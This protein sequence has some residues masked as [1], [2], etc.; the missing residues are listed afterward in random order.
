MDLKSLIYIDAYFPQKVMEQPSWSRSYP[1]G[2]N[3][4]FLETLLSSELTFLLRYD[5]RRSSNGDGGVAAIFLLDLGFAVHTPTVLPWGR[6]LERNHASRF[7]G[8]SDF[9]S[10]LEILKASQECREQASPPSGEPH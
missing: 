4:K 3:P 7:L 6:T 10:A 1:Q 8:F 5:S 2:R 9:H